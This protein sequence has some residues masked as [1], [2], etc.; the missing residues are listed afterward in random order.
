MFQLVEDASWM[1]WLLRTKTLAWLSDVPVSRQGFDNTVNTQNII[2]AVGLCVN[3]PNSYAAVHKQK[4]PVYYNPI[5]KSLMLYVGRLCVYITSALLKTFPS[6][7]PVFFSKKNLYLLSCLLRPSFHGQMSKY[8]LNIIRY[9]WWYLDLYWFYY[10]LQSV[11]F[12]T[13]RPCCVAETSLMKG[14]M[15]GIV[16]HSRVYASNVQ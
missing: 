12:V 13:V 6:L 1:S 7:K 16:S 10:F 15:T 5:T 9:I 8:S 3:W 4:V 14:G 11:V 2:A